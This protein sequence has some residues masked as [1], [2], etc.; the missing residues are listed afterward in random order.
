MA[1]VRLLQASL[2]ENFVQIKNF[3]LLED[4][5][6]T[7]ANIFFFFWESIPI[8]FLILNKNYY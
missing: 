7:L 2:E 4:Q 8:I 5:N 6:C 1:W 3:L